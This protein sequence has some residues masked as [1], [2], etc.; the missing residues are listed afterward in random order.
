MRVLISAVGY[1]L[2]SLALGANVAVAAHAADYV[3]AGMGI[4]VGLRRRSRPAYR[5]PT[6]DRGDEFY[7]AAQAKRAR[8]NARRAE[9]AA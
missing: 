3:R 5:T 2:A 7:A 8:K 6:V 1:A 9:L 4:P